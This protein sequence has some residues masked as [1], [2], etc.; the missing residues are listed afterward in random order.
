MTVNGTALSTSDY[1][2]SGMKITIPANKITGN[3]VITV[4]TEKVNTGP[5]EPEEPGIGGENVIDITST[6]AF[7]K[8]KTGWVYKD[9]TTKTSTYLDSTDKTDISSYAGCLMVTSCINFTASSGKEMGYG[10]LFF[11]NSDNL[12]Y[13]HAFPKYT[14][15]GPKGTYVST[16]ISIPENAKYFVTSKMNSDAE[17]N[18]I[19]DGDNT[20]Y[21]KIY[22]N[23]S[24]NDL[25]SSF[26]FNKTGVAQRVSTSGGLAIGDHTS[27]YWN[28]ATLDVS[29][30]AGHIIEISAPVGNTNDNVQFPYGFIS[31]DSNGELTVIHR[32]K[33]LTGYTGLVGD[34]ETIYLVLPNNI[35]YLRV[36]YFSSEMLNAT[37]PISQDVLNGFS[38]KVYN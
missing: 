3:V 4:A 37:N 23:N 9:G 6:L 29:E 17:N 16:V 27:K 11:D 28:S 25:T 21:C 14:S 20:Y 10:I 5:E 12:I 15:S 13:A 24:S 8:L 22:T 31:E 30:Y 32:F 36:C 35:K 2:V 38:C 26:V 33:H 19:I 1:T 7:S 34:V 18:G